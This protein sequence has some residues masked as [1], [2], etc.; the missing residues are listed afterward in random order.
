MMMLTMIIIIMMV[1][2]DDVDC[3]MYSSD[4]AVDKADE[5]C[6]GDEDDDI[7]NGD[8]DG[9]DYGAYDCKDNDVMQLQ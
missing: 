9:D 4:D 7:D 3:T 2:G 6:I 5:L 1:R 8:D